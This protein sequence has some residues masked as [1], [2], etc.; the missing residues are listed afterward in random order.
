MIIRQAARAIT[1]GDRS[2]LV[3]RAPQLLAEVYAPSAVTVNSANMAARFGY[4][5]AGWASFFV[6]QIAGW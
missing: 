2:Q 3:G 6:P 5:R 1:R 4:T